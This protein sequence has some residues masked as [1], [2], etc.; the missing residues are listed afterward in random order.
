[1]DDLGQFLSSYGDEWI[2]SGHRDFS[3]EV[4]RIATGLSRTLLG[5][6]ALVMA[7]VRFVVEQRARKLRWHIDQIILRLENLKRLNRAISCASFSLI[8]L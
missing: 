6:P 3:Y 8:V 1:M 4:E 2:D 5:L 7:V